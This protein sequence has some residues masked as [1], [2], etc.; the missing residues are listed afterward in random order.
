MRIQTLPTFKTLAWLVA[1]NIAMT[2]LHYVDNV[3]FFHEYPEPPWLRPGMVDA[4]WFLMTPVALAGLWLMRRDC[5]RIGSIVLLVY[6]T[7]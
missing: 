2:I 6:A 7:E 1:L 4:F 3:A 5:R